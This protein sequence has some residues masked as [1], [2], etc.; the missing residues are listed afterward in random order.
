MPYIW[1][2]VQVTKYG[3]KPFQ[4]GSCE[5]VPFV[6]MID[7]FFSVWF[8]FTDTDDFHVAVEERRSQ[9]ATNI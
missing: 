9:G 6:P 3:E 1:G 8:S 4:K 7:L 5:G 2:F